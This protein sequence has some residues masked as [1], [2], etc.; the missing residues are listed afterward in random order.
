MRYT[1]KYDEIVLFLFVNE[2][3]SDKKIPV[4]KLRSFENDL[5]SL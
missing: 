2:F 4:K 5:R 3:F 1:K